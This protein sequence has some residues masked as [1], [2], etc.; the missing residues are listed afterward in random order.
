MH[1]RPGGV[2]LALRWGPGLGRVWE[3]GRRQRVQS[4][5]HRE[6]TLG[7]TGSHG[8]PSG[9]H[10]SCSQAGLGKPW[11]FG[12]GLPSLGIQQVLEVGEAGGWR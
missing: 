7:T 3:L 4:G 9:P 5:A 10:E 2:P 11:A 12:W 1:R 8:A 6:G